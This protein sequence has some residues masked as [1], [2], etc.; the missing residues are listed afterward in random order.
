M[1][2][3]KLTT[4]KGRKLE[5]NSDQ[6]LPKQLRLSDCKELLLVRY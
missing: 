4:N 2:G 3:F 1:N 5:V 6:L